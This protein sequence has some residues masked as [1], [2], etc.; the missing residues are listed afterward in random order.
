[1]NKKQ[2]SIALTIVFN[3]LALGLMLS[4]VWEYGF[5]L[6][7]SDS[8]TY[9]AAAYDGIIPIDLPMSYSW[10]LCLSKFLFSMRFA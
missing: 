7:Y 3:L 1:M 6:L 9:M 2:V 5:P 10:F 4:P 8:G